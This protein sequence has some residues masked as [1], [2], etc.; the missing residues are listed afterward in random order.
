MPINYR[1][2]KAR[3]KPKIFKS[4]KPLKKGIWVPLSIASYVSGYTNQNLRLLCLQG[5]VKS[6]KFEVGPM[7]VEIDSVFKYR[8]RRKSGT[9]R[10]DA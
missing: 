6:A 9:L 1:Y 7:L 8:E 3:Y 2:I 4:E 10:N 5:L